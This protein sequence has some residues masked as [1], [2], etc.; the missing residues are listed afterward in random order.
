MVHALAWCPTLPGDPVETT[1]AG[2]T[3]R[4]GLLAVLFTDLAGSTEQRARL[5]DVAGDA[6]RREHD[7]IV[8]RALR[9]HGGELVKGTGD[10]SMCSFEST[11][12]ALAAA[13]VIQQGVERRNRGAVEPLALRAGISAGELVFDD[14]DLHGLAAN[15][16]ARICALAE[17]GE[18][19]VGDVARVLAASRAGCEWVERGS[20]AL[21]G[22]PEPVQVWGVRWSP[23]PDPERLPLPSLLV[24]E[25]AM[26]FSGRHDEFAVMLDAWAQAAGGARRAVLVSGEP[27]IGKTRL[28]AEV[29]AVAHA[30]GAVVLYG[31]CD[32]ELEVPFQPFREALSWYL[33]HTAE[34]ELGR[35][36][37][38]LTRLSER[39]ADVVLDVPDPLDADAQSARVPAL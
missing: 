39:V 1:L 31:R 15:E 17:P 3:P 22:L 37:G 25:E 30:Q 28:A 20:Y 7:A 2:V 38:D 10:G 24:S 34:V 32:D 13:V 6:L 21:K 33:D 8:A 26:A 29:A 4:S 12:D 19:L 11:V 16:A 14:G 27:G 35:W 23:A 9:L 36:P 5:G 18:V